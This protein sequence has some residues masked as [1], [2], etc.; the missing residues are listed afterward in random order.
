MQKTA[1]AATLHTFV[2]DGGDMVANEAWRLTVRT[3]ELL[4]TRYAC[5]D[6][7]Y[8]WAL[9]GPCTCGGAH[10]VDAFEVTTDADPDLVQPRLFGIAW[11]WCPA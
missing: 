5:T 7:R 3:G 1:T 10:E 4:M 9:A 2:A 8:S 6:G 11:S